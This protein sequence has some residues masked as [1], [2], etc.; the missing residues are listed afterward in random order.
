[1]HYIVV[2]LSIMLILLLTCNIVFLLI[3]LQNIFK[4]HYTIVFSPQDI[5]NHAWSTFSW[6]YC[7]TSIHFPDAFILFF[8]W[9]HFTLLDPWKYFAFVG[10]NDLLGFAGI[11]GV[12]S[13]T[14][15]EP[16]I[17]QA[18]LPGVKDLVHFTNLHHV[19]LLS[20][21]CKII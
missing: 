12:L 6:C 7:G 10:T 20:S 21:C 8:F 9:N 18:L 13:F 4:G 5:R 17:S 19:I 14:F 15:L 3:F 16:R 2:E 11:E 1:M